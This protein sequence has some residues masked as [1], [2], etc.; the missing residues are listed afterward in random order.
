M[1][2]LRDVLF[3]SSSWP[4][5]IKHLVV[6]IAAFLLMIT[7]SVFCS[8]GEEV[9]VHEGD[10]FRILFLNYHYEPVYINALILEQT[11][12]LHLSL[13]V[14][15]TLAHFVHPANHSTTTLQ[16]LHTAGYCLT[17]MALLYTVALLVR[18]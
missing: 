1:E 4:Q 12:Q 7:T 17:I 2:E 10:T 18:H 14:C 3:I 13:V 5:N 6:I 11:G 8:T 15:S 16:L 9:V